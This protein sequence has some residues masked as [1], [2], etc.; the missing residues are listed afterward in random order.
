MMCDGPVIIEVLPIIDVGCD[1][2][3]YCWSHLVV[4]TD[5]I[6]YNEPLVTQ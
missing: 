1:I 2:S 3:D 5:S 4:I 6:H